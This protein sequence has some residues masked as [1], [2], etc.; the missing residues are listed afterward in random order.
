MLVGNYADKEADSLVQIIS[1][2]SP[3]NMMIIVYVNDEDQQWFVWEITGK[4]VLKF[5]VTV[6]ERRPSWDMNQE[7]LTVRWEC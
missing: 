7:L 4:S 1:R 3:P 5:A 6:N 2:Y